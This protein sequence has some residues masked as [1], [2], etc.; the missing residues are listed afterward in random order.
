MAIAYESVSSTV[1]NGVNVD[2]PI[3]INKP[4]GTAEGDVLVAFIRF[5][6]G[7]SVTASGWTEVDSNTAYHKIFMLYKV[8]GSSEPA[9]YSF[10]PDAFVTA[11]GII[12]RFSGVDTTTPS[13]ATST[14][15]SGNSAAPRGLSVTTASDDAMLVLGMYF[16]GSGNSSTA[17]SGMTEAS[18]V[19]YT[20]ANYGTQ[21]SA[22]ASGNKD[23][24]LTSSNLWQTIMWALKPASS[25]PAAQTI[26]PTP[27][28][29]TLT[30]VAASVSTTALASTVTATPASLTLTSVAASVSV[31]AF[32]VA[33]S[34]AALTLTGVAAAISVGAVTVTV[35]PTA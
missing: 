33:A 8:A 31:G 35:T 16:A 34:P 26:T 9:T 32:T 27:A 22:G 14:D 13:D 25:G 6:G 5:S 1:D 24:T 4:S 29:L 23:A 20:S 11:S 12:M 15:N 19:Q 7:A 18:E 30:G 10:E 17:P 28:T 21:A 2:D 3:V